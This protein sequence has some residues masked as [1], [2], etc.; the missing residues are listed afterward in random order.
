M[1]RLLLVLNGAAAVALTASVARADPLESGV[2]ECN[3]AP[4]PGLIIGSSREVSCV[5][6]PVSGR[7]EY[8]A[9]RISRFGLDIG[10]AGPARFAWAVYSTN[11]LRHRYALSG[12]YAGA[13][14]GLALGAGPWADAL[15]GGEGNGV[16]LTPLSS[17]STG[18]NLSAGMGSLMLRPSSIPPPLLRDP[19]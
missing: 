4:G 1:K 12:Y 11:P 14:A 18:I 13:G 15:V 2:L 8:Y 3:V 19:G 5:F 9:G 10:V 17:T 6:H 7:P 16:S